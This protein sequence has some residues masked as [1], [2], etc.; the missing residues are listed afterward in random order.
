MVVGFF[1]LGMIDESMG[2]GIL[3]SHVGQIH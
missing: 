2:W 1:I 3:S